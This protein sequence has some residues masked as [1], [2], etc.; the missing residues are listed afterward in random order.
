MDL[1]K[2]MWDGADLRLC[3]VGGVSGGLKKIILKN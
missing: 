2:V 3:G 1:I